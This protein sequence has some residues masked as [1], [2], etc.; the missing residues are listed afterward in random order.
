MTKLSEHDRDHLSEKAFAFPKE[1]KEPLTDARHV[2]NAVARCNQV[3]GVSNAERDEAWKRIQEAAKRFS[4]DLKYED[5]R[6]L[7]WDHKQH[8]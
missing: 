4:V 3:E 5:W 1:Q 7:V 8:K 2:Q 6:D